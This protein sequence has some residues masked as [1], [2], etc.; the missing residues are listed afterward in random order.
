MEKPLVLTENQFLKVWKFNFQAQLK[1]LYLEEKE[2][3]DCNQRFTMN[4]DDF[5]NNMYTN[6]SEF[7]NNT[8]N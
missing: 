4:Y 1:E 3:N 8:L 2:Y 6:F 7:I 5:C